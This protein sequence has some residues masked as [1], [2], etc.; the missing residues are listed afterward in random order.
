MSEAEVETLKVEYPTLPEEY[1]QYLREKGWGE[2]DSGRMIY[3]GPIAPHEVYG[4][5][6]QN[7]TVVLLGDDMQGYCFGFDTASEVFGEISDSGKW[8]PWPKGELFKDYVIA[9][10]E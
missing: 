7:S 5:R 4:A 6:F 3:Q 8:E 9:Q 1:F 10:D 2:A